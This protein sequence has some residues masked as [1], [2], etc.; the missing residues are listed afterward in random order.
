M[1][2]PSQRV[3]HFPGGRADPTVELV[4][5]LARYA[6]E[7]FRV[8][9]WTPG[10]L[11]R[12]F[13]P[14]KRFI[15]AVRVLNN[16]P[17]EVVFNRLLALGV[18]DG[19]WETTNTCT[20]SQFYKFCNWLKS[21]E[22]TTRLNEIRKARHLEKKAQPGQTL[23][24]VSLV[25]ALDEQVAEFQQR[26]KETRLEFESKLIDLRRQ[27][28]LV[29]Q[30]MSATM[31]AHD[32]DFSPA[33]IYEPMD[34]LEF[35]EACWNL[36][37]AECA[38]LNQDEAPLDDGLLE[39]V[40]LT[41]G[42]AALAMHKANFLRV[43]FNR[44]NLKHWIEEKILELDTVGEARRATT[45]V[46][47]WQQRVERWLMKFELK[48]RLELLQQVV[49]G[50][51][52]AEP[53]TRLT[54]RMSNLLDFGLVLRREILGSKQ[55]A[56]LSSEIERAVLIPPLLWQNQRLSILRP[57][58]PDLGGRIPH[59]RSRYEAKVRKVI[60]GGEM[61]DWRAANAMYRGG[62]SFSD[63]L[64]LLID[65]R[66]DAPGAILS[67]KWKVDSARRYLLLPCGLPV[68][69]GPEATKMK[70]FNDDA[71]AGPA[72]RAFG[73]LR[74]SG[75]KTSLEEFAWNCLD[76]FARGGAA[77]DCLP[78]VAARVGYRTKLLTLSDA[79]SKI[80]SCKP[81]GRCVMMLDAHEQAFSSP[82]YNVL[83]NLTHLSRFQRNSGF[84]NSIVRASSD[85][86]MLWKDV[87]AASCVVELD[88][89]K[90]DR[91]RPADD[92]S[93]MIDVII[94]CFE[95]KDDYEERLLLGYRI[96][97]NRAL[98]ERCFVTDDGGVFHIDGMVPSG[99][100]WTGWLDTAL[101]ILY[102]GAALRH[103][104]PD[105]SQAV[106][107]C[108]G[109]DNLTL[110]YTDLPDAS[111]LNLKK[112]LNEWFRAGIEDE[113]FIIHRPPYHITRFQATFPP[114]TDLSKGTSHLLDSAKWIQIHGIM[115]I[116]EA[117]G[118][119]HRWKYS[120]AGKPKFLSCYWEE[121]GNPIRPAHV[122]LEKL[123]WP[124][125]IHKTIDDYL[126]A[127]IS[128]V[129]DNPFNHHN[130]NHMMHRFCI[131]QQVK[132]LS[133][134]GIRDDHI[135]SLAHI[136]GKEGEMVPFPMV[137]EWRRTQGWV[138]MESMPYLKKYISDFRHFAAGVMSLY[139]RQP[140]GGI[141]AW[142]F[143]DMIRGNVLLGGEQF[144]NDFRDWIKFLQNN[145]LTSYLKPMRRF[146]PQKA[147]REST[148]D[149]IS[150]F[151]SFSACCGIG[152]GRTPFASTESYG[153]WIA[154]LVPR[155]QH[156]K[157][158]LA[159]M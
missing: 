27:I 32:A 148:E 120:F 61:R 97:L 109:D 123:L 107:K 126:A 42:N 90:F 22:G 18:R 102:I 80:N 26:K 59:S 143:M 140:G 65:A 38:R 137:A 15:D 106:A 70:N 25:A 115:N 40:K 152:D 75:L 24:D 94:S 101:N 131:I 92:I 3:V 130:V 54:L 153:S 48:L 82:L 79:W 117:A 113:D 76:A 105:T 111:L 73:I 71:T 1:S 31:K 133:V 6:N 139:A 30:E 159:T 121:N 147:A 142:R 50:V 158:P 86:A 138:D 89:K 35:G 155:M 100:L 129:V 39:A 146:R 145:P 112:Y 66:E 83:S 8:H 132:R 19:W 149:I 136:R 64:K 11:A 16:E 128:M 141:D 99:S 96:M 13:I 67:E 98:I 118:L 108:A 33:S 21:A 29:Q 51:P 4:E 9:T 63:A 36:Y 157:A 14:V 20:V 45:F 69:R 5:S 28:A 37:R 85:W 44:N 74:K 47:T 57:L 87:S 55:P 43:G 68:P 134:A 12:S 91:E 49:L 56:P 53:G 10:I 135:L 119:S 154:D 151:K 116:D 41:H 17:D 156:G 52:C 46:P 78:F 88:W 77:E 124:E 23:E 34:D 122:N 127:V 84:C 95:A 81:L 125:G 110:F 103:V 144:G 2:G 93:F 62:G 150:K 60:G 104:L 7:G 72:L 114:G 58:R